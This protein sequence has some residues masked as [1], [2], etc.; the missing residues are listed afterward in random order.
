MFLDWYLVKPG[1]V[2]NR[3][4]LSNFGSEIASLAV[5]TWGL[6]CFFSVVGASSEESIS[7]PATVQSVKA[8]VVLRGTGPV[9]GPDGSK[10]QLKLLLFQN[11]DRQTVHSMKVDVRI[12]NQPLTEKSLIRENGNRFAK[13][14]TTRTGTLEYRIEAVITTD[15]MVQSLED[16]QVDAAAQSH[17]E[18]QEPTKHVESDHRRIRQIGRDQFS[19]TSWLETVRDVTHWTNQYIT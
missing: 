8:R 16:A 7:H 9:M 17:R 4:R 3:K 18:Y 11:T 15:Y 12:D 2:N 1:T 10:I 5:M 13:F 14:E 19:K 6:L